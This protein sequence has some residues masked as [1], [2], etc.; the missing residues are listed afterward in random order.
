M[1]MLQHRVTTIKGRQLGTTNVSARRITGSKLQDRRITMW[2]ASPYCAM[3]GRVVQYPHGF[4]LD[5]KV[6]LSQGG[7]DTADNC[8]I[9][10]VEHNGPQKTGCHV[11]KTKSEAIV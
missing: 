3:C 10:C 1:R 8:Q 4:E 7:S 5:H 11:I 9:L 6:P 2:A